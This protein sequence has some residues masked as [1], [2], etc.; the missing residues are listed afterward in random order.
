MRNWG[1]AKARLEDAM[2]GV[3][4]L[5]ALATE[6]GIDDIFQDNGGKVL[7]SL[8]FL[9]LEQLPGREGNDAT[10]A[11]GRQYELK[12][13]NVLKQT[14][15]TTHHHLNA[16]ILA[17]YRGVAAWYISLY[18]GINLMEIYRVE[19]AGLEHLFSEWERRIQS[20]GE[21]LNNPKIPLTV[22]ADGITNGTATLVYSSSPSTDS[23]RVLDRV[24]GKRRR[25]LKKVLQTTGDP[26]ADPN[27]PAS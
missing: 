15:V 6:H 12:T 11:E 13:I 17:K 20:A 5:Q 19:T 25:Q 27:K 22:I 2:R 14:Q 1:E 3:R 8:I 7:Q 10:D 26:N 16:D 9:Q 21:P 18:E 4:E 24:I 23:Q